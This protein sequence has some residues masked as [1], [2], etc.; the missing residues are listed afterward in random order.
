MYQKSKL[1]RSTLMQYG[2]N[3]IL[4]ILTNIV[5]CIKHFK[6][7]LLHNYFEVTPNCLKISYIILIYMIF[8]PKLKF[9]WSNIRVM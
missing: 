1:S 5:G 9:L 2:E 8:V 6:Y 7:F 4:I 3:F